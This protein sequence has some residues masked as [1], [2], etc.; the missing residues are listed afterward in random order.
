[1]TEPSETPR[2]PTMPGTSENAKPEN[3]RKTVLVIGCGYLGAQLL[4][5]LTGIGWLAAG[6]TLS[7]SSAEILRNQG[8]QVAAA[9]LRTSDFQLLTRNNPAVIIHCASSGRGGPAAYREIF[10]ETTK[11]L[12]KE[13]S[14]SHL[15]FTSSTSVYA[16]ID[17][18]AVAETAPAEPERETGKILIE[19]EEI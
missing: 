10:L 13:A 7:E 17:G 8:L 11:R 16:Q 19:T 2:P 9:D 3:D 18:S 5:E 14:C 1:M 12:I 15:I 4:R 6:I